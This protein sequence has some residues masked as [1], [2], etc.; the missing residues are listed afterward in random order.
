MEELKPIWEK[1]EEHEIRLRRLENTLSELKG[2]LRFNT[3]LTL[4]ILAAI[5]SLIVIIL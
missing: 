4:T 3:G 5:L 2:E 1:L